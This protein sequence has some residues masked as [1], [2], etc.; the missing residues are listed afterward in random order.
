[1]PPVNL[2]LHFPGIGSLLRLK[3]APATARKMLLEAHKWT[4]KEALQEGIVDAVVPPE[5]MLEVAV[6]WGRRVAPRAK[7]GVF[8]LL[9]N[10]LYGEAGRAFREISFVYGRRTGRE[11]KAK[12]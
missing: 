11:A 1:M 6:E 5:R 4:G 12:I 8:S 10:E 9:R 2:G 3:L 7:M